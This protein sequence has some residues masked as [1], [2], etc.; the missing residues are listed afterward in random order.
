MI[1]LN[2]TTT[3]ILGLFDVLKRPQGLEVQDE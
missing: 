2:M 1:P 3:L